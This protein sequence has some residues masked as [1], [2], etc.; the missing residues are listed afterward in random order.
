MIWYANKIYY[1]IGVSIIKELNMKR[2]ILA[3]DTYAGI[4]KNAINMLSGF[5]SGLISYTLPVRYVQKL[6]SEEI[7]ENNIIAVGCCE[8]HPILS[9]YKQQGLL[10][11]PKKEEGYSIYVGE[12]DK[13]DSQTIAIAGADE[14]GVLYGCMQ[15]L[16]EY[17]GSKLYEKGDLWSG[18]FFDFPLEKRLPKYNI[19]TYP[20][21]KNRAIWT[22]GYVIYDYKAFFDNMARLRLN[23]V[24]IW[25][26]F[27]PF[28]AKDIVEY[29][30]SLGIKVIFGFSC[31][32]TT[33][34][35][36]IMEELC[37]QN[38]LQTLKENVLYTY[39]TQY[40]DTDCDGIYFQSFTEM[41]TDKVNGKCVAEIVT[42][43]VNDIAGELLKQYPTLHIQFGLHATSV[44]EH[45]DILATVD[46]R[47]RIVWEDCG[48]FPYNYYPDSI[49]DFPETY[50]LTKKLLLL[51]GQ[52]EKFGAVFKGMLKLDW[53]TFEHHKGSFI[54]GERTTSFINERQTIKNKIW[55]IIRGDWLKNAEFLRKTI[56]L[57][58]QNGN[59]A[60][61]QALV[62]DSMFEN[63]ITLPVAIYA[64]LLWSPNCAI[65]DVLQIT[66]K[67]PFVEN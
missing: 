16:G 13:N 39:K 21:V 48:A 24:V 10:A 23:E 60:I 7:K 55:K 19:S 4:Q 25:N 31:G 44:K 36:Q 54:L 32:W 1:I 33:N 22:W 47:V 28:N 37:S 3:I 59:D 8:T 14:K 30:H 56:E 62:E 61:V 52:N 27:V 64:Q 67:N 5:L 6:S 17:C 41:N 26:D 46:K 66:S 49:E 2:W 45:L 63:K 51:R 34:C 50:E 18:K 11:P 12:T 65:D 35:E 29:A 20:A 42:E 58:V 40:A 43:L 53:G 9:D 38:G 57:I 15:F